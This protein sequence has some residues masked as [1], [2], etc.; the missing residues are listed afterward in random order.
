MLF[1]YI[2]WLLD[3]SN[4]DLEEEMTTFINEFN[5]FQLSSRYPD[6]ANDIYKMCTNEFTSEQLEKIKDIRLC[7]LEM[8]P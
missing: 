4:I 2:V 3:E 8:L 5:K 6:Y 1:R 7:L